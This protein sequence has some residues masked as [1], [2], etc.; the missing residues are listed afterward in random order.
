MEPTAVKKTSH[1]PALA[2]FTLWRSELG[3]SGTGNAPLLRHLCIIQFTGG[4]SALSSPS[5]HADSYRSLSDC[6]SGITSI[7]EG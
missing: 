7:K 4:F 1:Y 6:L 5:R 2:A 3:H